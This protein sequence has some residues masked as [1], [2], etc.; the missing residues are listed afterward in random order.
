MQRVPLSPPPPGV[1]VP[2]GFSPGNRSVGDAQGAPNVSAL[3]C[4]SSLTAYSGSSLLPA[5]CRAAAQSDVA[6]ARE[7][8]SGGESILRELSQLRMQCDRQRVVVADAERT[9]EAAMQRAAVAEAEVHQ[10]QAALHEERL[11]HTAPANSPVMIQEYT[12]AREALLRD[13]RELQS[14]VKTS[15]ERE[16][17]LRMELTRVDG[18]GAVL[19]QEL[20]SL[21]QSLLT[22][23]QL[24]KARERTLR[25]LQEQV[26]DQTSRSRD[27]SAELR[28]AQD[29]ANLSGAAAD[30]T[31]QRWKDASTRAEAAE[32]E[33]RRLT[34]A[35]SAASL[36]EQQLHERLYNTE[37]RLR[38][39]RLG[40]SSVE[41]I[42]AVR[43]ELEDEH[44]C[45]VDTLRSM[46]AERE[47]ELRAAER[48]VSVVHRAVKDAGRHRVCDTET[49]ARSAVAVEEGGA[50]QELLQEARTVAREHCDRIVA[51]LVQTHAES[52][53][54]IREE[55]DRRRR[56]TDEKMRS[57]ASQEIASAFEEGKTAGSAPPE[58]PT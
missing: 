4:R 11:R 36:R 44:R 10:L 52:Y 7:G 34:A 18:E 5:V 17:Q 12:A 20:Q 9:S 21:Q 37:Q 46:L 19:K 15:G 41:E 14:Q 55:F 29:S 47:R 28:I 27:A 3:S 56:R 39:A 2:N 22:S 24:L 43:E 53:K 58:G 49:A 45:E 38:D 16:Q 32:V 35:L 40:D 33:V 8:C 54:A 23:E 6:D 31:F 48:S 25:R 30:D 42:Q 1:E 51:G 13:L 50:M 57:V 26:A